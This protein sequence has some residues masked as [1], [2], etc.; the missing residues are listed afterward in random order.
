MT[1]TSEDLRQFK[2]FHRLLCERFGYPHDEKDWFRDQVSLIEHIANITEGQIEEL[3]AEVN[4]VRDGNRYF[5]LEKLALDRAAHAETENARLKTLLL[6]NKTVKKE[7]FDALW[8][9]V[10][11]TW[12]LLDGTC[13]D[14]TLGKDPILTVEKDDFDSLCEAM[15]KLEGL[16]PDEE[17][18]FWGGF[19]V[20]YFLKDLVKK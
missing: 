5:Q 19:P 9:V 17:K 1:D 10:H 4:R 8:A 7:V 6:K 14:H 12:I 16:I 15:D 11:Q 18:P 13:E 2:N 20:S 3:R